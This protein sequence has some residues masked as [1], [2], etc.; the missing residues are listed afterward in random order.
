MLDIRN[1]K[2]VVANLKLGEGKVN[3]SIRFRKPVQKDGEMEKSYS[4]E[5]FNTFQLFI[6]SFCKKYNTKGTLLF[7]KLDDEPEYSIC[8]SNFSE[9]ELSTVIWQTIDNLNG[10]GRIGSMITFTFF[11]PM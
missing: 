8:R 2:F 1:V 5:D 7:Y 4:L 11:R 3:P 10:T 9:N 6:D